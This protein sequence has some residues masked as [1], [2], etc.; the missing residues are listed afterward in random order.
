MYA[1]LYI[2]ENE[3]DTST[4]DQNFDANRLIK[5]VN[6]L[7]FI[8]IYHNFRLEYVSKMILA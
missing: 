4:Y 2:I 7:L 6:S 8:E 3:R 5:N 1:L